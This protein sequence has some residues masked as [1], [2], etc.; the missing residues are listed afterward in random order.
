MIA[1]ALIFVLALVGLLGLYNAAHATEPF[2]ASLYCT[3]EADAVTLME[4]LMN[5]EM[6]EARRLVNTEP[7]FKCYHQPSPGIG[8]MINPSIYSEFKAQE[9]GQSCVIEATYDGGGE[10]QGKTVYAFAQQMECWIVMGEK[11][12]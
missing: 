6:R 3:E 11:G 7:T 10:Y 8:P 1:R 2:A 5:G 12:A 4:L 9:Q